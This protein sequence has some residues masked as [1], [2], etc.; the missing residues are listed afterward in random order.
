[1]SHAPP[2]AATVLNLE[3]GGITVRV[4]TRSRRLASKLRHR[5]AGFVVGAEER[6]SV[7]L[8]VEVVRHLEAERVPAPVAVRQV[9]GVWH[10]KRGD[11]EAWC[12]LRS[13]EGRVRQRCEHEATESVIRILHSLW[14]TSRGGMLL[15]AASAVRHG[16]AYVCAG[17]SGAGKSTLAR[18]APAEAV[19]LSDEISYVRPEGGAY[20]AFGTPFAGDLGRGGENVAAP[21][22]ML[23]FLRQGEEHRLRRLPAVQALRTLLQHILFF[24]RDPGAVRQVFEAAQALVQQVPVYQ[25]TFRHD[26]GVWE[27][28]P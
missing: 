14:L 24:A 10:L 1:M 21:L 16:R 15:H 19:V 2:A 5:F 11:F 12:D 3:I 17:Y 25:L 26:P 4:A 23:C 9:D 18:M 7:V 20:R 22:A 27:L 28:L 8:N 13:A 6:P